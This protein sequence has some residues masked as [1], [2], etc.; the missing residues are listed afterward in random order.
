MRRAVLWAFV[1]LLAISMP[2]QSA[3]PL[4]GAVQR[5]VQCFM[6]YSIAVDTAVKAKD[7]KT[8][9]AASLGVMY[10]VG[11]LAV[12]SPGLNLADAIRQEADGMTGN[13]RAKEI[14]AACDTEFAKRAQQLLDIGQQLQTPANQSSSSS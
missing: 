2:A 13:P 14:G 3:V 11:K 12:E 6:L 4:S 7:E 8:Q 5:D 1:S 10:F 9:E